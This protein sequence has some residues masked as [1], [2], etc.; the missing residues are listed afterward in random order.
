MALIENANHASCNLHNTTEE[1][2]IKLLKKKIEE[3]ISNNKSIIAIVTNTFSE[4]RIH[5]HVEGYELEKDYL[6]LCEKN[7]E[8]HIAFNNTTEIKYDD[9]DVEC[10]I[11]KCK[12][13]NETILMF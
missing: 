11:I 13:N 4:C 7:N 12:D 10:F 1:K 8:I 5:L 3:C 6:Y 9:T 2:N